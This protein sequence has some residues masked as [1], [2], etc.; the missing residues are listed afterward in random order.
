MFSVMASLS[1]RARSRLSQWRNRP[2]TCHAEP[3][4]V[5]TTRS[6]AGHAHRGLRMVFQHSRGAVPP[7]S[8]LACGALQESRRESVAT[9]HGARSFSRHIWSCTPMFLTRFLTSISSGRGSDHD[10]LRL[11]CVGCEQRAGGER[12]AAR[13]FD[14][15]AD[16]VW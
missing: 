13:F 14:P 6:S 11:S 16:S 15:C 10:I 3:V 7:V 1:M 2:G 5:T 8:F 12:P 4:T 9:R